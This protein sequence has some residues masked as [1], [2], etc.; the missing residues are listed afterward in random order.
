V[1]LPEGESDPADLVRSVLGFVPTWLDTHTATVLRLR[2]LFD[3]DFLSQHAGKDGFAHLFSSIDV[4]A[5]LQGRNAVHAALYLWAK[6]VLPEYILTVLGD[7]MEMA[8]SVEG[9]VPFLDHH[10]A[11]YLHRVPVAMKIRG[12]TEKYILREAVKDVVTEAVYERQKHPFLSPP[13][14]LHPG[15]ELH[16]FLQDT[17]RGSGVDDVPFLDRKKISSYLDGLLED[18]MDFGARIVADQVLTL[19]LSCV[20]L[21][22]G[23]GL[24]A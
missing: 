18:E 9:R 24:E 7:R 13:A 20:L 3:D 15:K 5:R 10:V 21:Q 1:L 2:G 22:E 12:T 14:T 6:T 17:L 16:T 4:P 19:A 23:L 11:E 8:H